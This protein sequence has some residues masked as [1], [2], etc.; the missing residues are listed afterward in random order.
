MQAFP[1]NSA[2]C[3]RADYTTPVNVHLRFFPRPPPHPPNPKHARTL[4]VSRGGEWCRS[5][6]SLLVQVNSVVIPIFCSSTANQRHG[7]VFP[8]Q[9]NTRQMGRVGGSLRQQFSWEATRCSHFGVVRVSPAVFVCNQG[10]K[11]KPESVPNHTT[12]CTVGIPARATRLCCVR[13]QKINSP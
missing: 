4:E 13:A 2:C 1:K 11:S 7:N 6:S 9:V 8:L 5:Y 3:P 12:S 10:A